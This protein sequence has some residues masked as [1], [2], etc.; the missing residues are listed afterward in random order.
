M[1]ERFLKAKAVVF[2]N[3]TGLTVAEISQLRKHLGDSLQYKVV[4]NTLA[5]KASEDTPLWI[6]NEYFKGQLGIAIGYDDPVNAIK[7]VIEFT[8]KNEKFKVA[9]GVIEGRLLNEDELKEIAELP[10]RQV[11]V[12]MLAGLIQSPLSKLAGGLQ[13]TISR[14]SSAMNALRDKKSKIKDKEV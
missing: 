8:K 5:R 7:K 10:S 11:L 4:K 1:K 12:S 9:V 6:A 13:A 2:T 3:Y 14:F